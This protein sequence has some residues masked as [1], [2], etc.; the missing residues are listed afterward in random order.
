M[1]DRPSG[2]PLALIRHGPTAWTKEKRL[3]GH[4]DVPLSDEG[5]DMVSRW[6]VPA[7]MLGYEW[8]TSPLGRAAE[9]A[10]LLGAPALAVEPRLKEMSYAAWEGRKL[11]DLR[12]ELGEAMAANEARGLDFRPDGGESPRQVQARLLPWLADVAKRGKPVLA[13][14]HH[15]IIRAV[16]S[17]ATGWDMTGRPPHKLVWGA[18]QTFALGDDGMP[19]VDRLNVRLEE[20]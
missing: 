7:S 19:S 11:S 12:A 13:V 18:A 10:R 14:T 20:T 2:T 8:V 16:L 1:V 4:T 15:G 17:L 3:Q 6:R 9:T 5:R